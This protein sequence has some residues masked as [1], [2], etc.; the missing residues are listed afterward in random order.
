[1]ST[2]FVHL[3]LHTE[4]SLLDG[5]CRIG[6][7]LDQMEDLSEVDIIGDFASRIP[8]EVIGNLLDIP[9]DERQPLR[10]WSL[11]ILSALEPGPEPQVLKTGNQAVVDFTDYLRRL[12]NDRRQTPGDP[13][14]G[15]EAEAGRRALRE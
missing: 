10:A 7:L 4:Y 6:E 3:H 11:A 8:I 12:V 1:M 9:R 14:V 13:A 5:A 15:G 2:E